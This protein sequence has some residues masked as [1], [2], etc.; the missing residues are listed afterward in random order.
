M[1][2]N[3]VGDVSVIT[4]SYPQFLPAAVINH[5]GKSKADVEVFLIHF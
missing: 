4:V 5:M 2:Y 1:R 3:R